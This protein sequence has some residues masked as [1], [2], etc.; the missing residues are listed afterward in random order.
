MLTS[1]EHPNVV[2][3]KEAFFDSASSHFCVVMELVRGGDLSTMIQKKLASI[4]TRSGR[5]AAKSCQD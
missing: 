5:S 3:Y 2:Q 1:I 4:N